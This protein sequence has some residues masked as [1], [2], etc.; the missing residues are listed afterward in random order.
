MKEIPCIFCH[1]Q[2]NDTVI[3]EN[4]YQGKRC[5][6]CGLIYIS[7]RPSLE[8]IVDLYGHNTAHISAEQH[9]SDEYRKRLYARHHLGIL[10]RFARGEKLLEIGAGAGFFLDE[11]RKSGFDPFGIEFNPQQAEFMR[12]RLGIPCEEKPLS[13]KI[14][15]ELTFDVIYH[16][17][18]ISHLYNPVQDFQAMNKLL[19][20]D[21]ILFFETGNF[22][23][24]NRSY[25]RYIPTF[26]Y[27]DH[28][29]FFGLNHLQ[30]LLEQSGFKMIYTKQYSILPQLWFKKKFGKNH[31]N[32]CFEE[33]EKKSGQEKTRLN[34][35]IKKVKVW[36]NYGLRYYIGSISPK[37]KRPQT[38]LICAKKKE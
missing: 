7:P 31:G 30:T 12:T 36:V 24:V 2:S 35:L 33:E 15:N 6:E 32:D 16:C 28:L 13:S 37:N 11:A 5:P 3:N 21:G 25:Y 26:M 10:N 38:I 9:I 22:A 18:V 34:G 29:F 8:I 19:N 4:G 17:D 14:F 20:K 23:E 1:V 27:P